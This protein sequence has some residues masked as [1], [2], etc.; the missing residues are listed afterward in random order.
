MLSVRLTS[1]GFPSLWDPGHSR[2]HYFG[3]SLIPSQKR[4]K[5]IFFKNN[6]SGV[7]LSGFFSP[8]VS[9]NSCVI[10]D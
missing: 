6:G 7:S 1:L 9:L 4:F 3:R 5:N 8:G 10:L 2:P